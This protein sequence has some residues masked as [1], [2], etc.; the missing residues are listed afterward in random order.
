[1]RFLR[2]DEVMSMV[3]L[4]R[5]TIW[6]LERTNEFPRRRQLGRNSVA[7]VEEEV[8]EWMASRVMVEMASRA[9]VEGGQ[10]SQTGVKKAVKGSSN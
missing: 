2:I 9:V 3:G 1:M 4:S 7:W 8:E 6:R 5:P 10:E